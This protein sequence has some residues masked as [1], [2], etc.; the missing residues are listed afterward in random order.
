[1][2]IRV[3]AYR[4]KPRAD[5]LPVSAMQEPIVSRAVTYGPSTAIEG[6]PRF[7]PLGEQNE[8]YKSLHRAFDPPPIFA[9]AKAVV[10]SNA[11]EF[12]RWASMGLLC[13][14]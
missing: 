10:A 1:M 11:A 9:D 7:C 13:K 3:I 4:D 12:T 8:P 5:L 6:G 14:P 2:T